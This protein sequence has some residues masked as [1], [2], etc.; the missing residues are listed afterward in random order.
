MILDRQSYFEARERFQQ[1]LE[2]IISLE[3]TLTD[4]LAQ[5]LAPYGDE[6][7][8]E[9]GR[10]HDLYPF[11]KNYPP[12][13]RGRAPKGTSIPWLE[14]GETVIGAYTI[15]ALA[16]HNATLKH[17]GLPSGADL[18]LMNDDALIHLDIKMTGPNDRVDE[19]V[20]SPNQLSG[21]GGDWVDDGILNTPVNIQGRRA[22]MVYQPE[23][24]PVYLLGK[25]SLLCVT[26][27]IKGVYEVSA[28][29]DQPLVYLELICAPNGLLAFTGP[30]YNQTYPELFIPGKDEKKHTKKRV[31]IRTEPLAEIDAWRRQRIWERN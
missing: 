20:A 22:K 23:L 9:I 30:N 14:V 15:R 21:D 2:T 26:T 13:Q 16:T 19:I 17:P 8:E 3:R 7:A 1:S 10:A 18:R 12:R 27:F 4:F 24:A 25:Q 28:M 5:T 31:R 29:G 11:W 6:M